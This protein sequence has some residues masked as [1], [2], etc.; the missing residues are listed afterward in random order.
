MI[1]RPGAVADRQAVAKGLGE[2]GL[3]CLYGIVHGFASCEM[4]GDGRG[5][6]AAGAMRVG[7]IDEFSLKHIEEPAVIEQI[8]GSICWQMTALD[9]HM[10]TAESMND[11]G[12]SPSVCECL[13]FNA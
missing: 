11:F 4:G 2:M 12:R 8:G 13:D 3:G 7:G 5:E 9:Q 6:R 10:F 1:C